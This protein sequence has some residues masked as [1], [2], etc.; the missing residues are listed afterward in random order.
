MISKSG[1]TN[2]TDGL[3]IAEPSTRVSGSPYDKL[4]AIEEHNHQVGRVYPTLADGVVIASAATVWVLGSLVEIVPA[5]TI[6]NKFD[7]HYVAVEDIAATDI[8]ELV[9]YQG[10]SDVEI[11]RCR[12]I[13]G[14]NFSE[15]LAVP[16][17]TPLIPANARIRAAL[18]SKAAAANTVTISLQ[19]HEY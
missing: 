11:A 1:V 4:H 15:E 5:S 3:N 9:L 19:Y 6:T 13:R 2:V 16:V 10:A 14:S 12:F 8:Y 18:A 17:M 7:I